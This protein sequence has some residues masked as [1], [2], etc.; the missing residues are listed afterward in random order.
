MIKVLVVVT[1]HF[2]LDGI[3][4][5]ATNYYIYQDHTRIKMDLL[6]INDIPIKLKV[7]IEK[8][9]D[10]HFIMNQRN[11]NPI[12]YVKSV[13]LLCRQNK[14]DL[15]H[16]HGNSNTMF[17]DL[18]AARLGGV[19]VRVAHSHNTKCNH[20]VI[21]RI[22]KPL[23]R[24]NVTDGF[25][26]AE[27][28]GM[29]L[30]NKGEFRV[31]NNGIDLDR[32]KFNALLRLRLRKELG[33]EN[34]LVVGHVGRFSKQKNHQKLIRIFKILNEMKKNTALLMWGEGE[35]EEDIQQMILD[36]NADIRLMGT[37][38]EVEK[39]LHVMDVIVFPSLFEGL[40]LFL[41]E[42]QALGIKCIVSDTVSPMAKIVDNFTYYSLNDTDEGWAKFI[43]KETISLE[44]IET[45]NMI[46]KAGYDIRNNCEQLLGI[47]NDLI[48]R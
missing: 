34:K 29:W 26:C 35:L 2:G 9:G 44:Y 30:F 10:S 31:I 48:Y 20:T 12:G 7:E 46:T 15:V 11:K 24:L 1:S 17:V 28:A 37:T 42:A 8:N 38:T 45:H 14:Y 18:I 22:L 3:S 5:V 25:A 19:K 33:V 13:A 4:N 6:T 27:E 16:I 47:Y 21:N 39:W 40:P 23:F 32:F 41:I 43:I 36:I